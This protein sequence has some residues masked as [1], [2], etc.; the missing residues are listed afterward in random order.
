MAAN[1]LT[2]FE[3]LSKGIHGGHNISRV[4]L[5]GDGCNGRARADEAFTCNLELGTLLSSEEIVR[6]LQGHFAGLWPMA[7]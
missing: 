2:C 7:H 5:M 1:Q 3:K 6:R 4:Y